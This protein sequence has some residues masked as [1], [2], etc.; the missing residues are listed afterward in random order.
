[1]VEYIYSR[2]DSQ[3]NA[4]CGVKFRRLISCAQIE[5]QEFFSLEAARHLI[6][7]LTT[8]AQAP[9]KLDTPDFLILRRFGDCDVRRCGNRMKTRAVWFHRSCMWAAANGNRCLFSS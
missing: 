3:T 5:N 9:R 6:G 8:L 4:P 7:Q 2:L 1:M